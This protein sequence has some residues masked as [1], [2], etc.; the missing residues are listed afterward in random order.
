MANQGEIKREVSEGLNEQ[1]DVAA[2]IEKLV[3]NVGKT[4]HAN[5]SSANREVK[6]CELD[7]LWKLF[8]ENNN[9]LANE[10][11]VGHPYHKDQLSALTYAQVKLGKERLATWQSL[12]E[13]NTAPATGTKPKAN[14][15]AEQAPQEKAGLAIIGESQELTTPG[16]NVTSASLIEH[17]DNM[18]IGNIVTT[19]V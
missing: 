12:K 13:A 18:Q 6:V 3:A 9:L 17:L 15:S 5:R 10:L 16:P 4:A 14:H 11:P 2:S 1:R 8:Q 7:S 19:S